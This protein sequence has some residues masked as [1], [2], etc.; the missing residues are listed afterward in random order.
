MATGH[1]DISIQGYGPVS[2]QDMLTET[3][4][5]PDFGVRVRVRVR[6]GHHDCFSISQ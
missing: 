3:L 1:C 6:V 4:R 2:V 5:Y